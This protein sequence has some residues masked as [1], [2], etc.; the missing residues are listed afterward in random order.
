[1]TFIQVS[2][3]VDI[4]L[5]QFTRDYSDYSGI[6]YSRNCGYKRGYQYSCRRQQ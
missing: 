6:Y 4:A 1:M 3:A 5:L 2:T